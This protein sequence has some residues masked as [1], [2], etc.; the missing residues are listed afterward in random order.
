MIKSSAIAKAA[1]ERGN[2]VTEVNLKNVGDYLKDQNLVLVAVQ[3]PH[4]TFVGAIIK[5]S[6][7]FRY[8]KKEYPRM[9]FM[10]VNNEYLPLAI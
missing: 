8:I 10:Q 7:E 5:S 6:D 1:K 3:E 4:Q 2:P 9:I